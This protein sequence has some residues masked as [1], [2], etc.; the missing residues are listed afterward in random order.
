LQNASLAVVQ[1]EWFN[2]SS[3]KLTNPSQVDDYMTSINGISRNL[4]EHIVNMADANVSKIA[5]YQSIIVMLILIA[6]TD[7][8]AKQVVL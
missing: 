1:Q 2:V 4:L 3:H 8:K 7:Y 6:V 5:Y